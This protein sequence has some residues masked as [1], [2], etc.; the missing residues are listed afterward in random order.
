MTACHLAVTLL[1]HK[2]RLQCCEF[3]MLQYLRLP[4]AFFVWLI[5][6]WLVAECASAALPLLPLMMH[7]HSMKTEEKQNILKLS[8]YSNCLKA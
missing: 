1:L 2:Q 8:L 5:S 6:W 7:C 4:P 3:E